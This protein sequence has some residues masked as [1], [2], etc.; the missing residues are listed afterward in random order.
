MPYNL[1]GYEG[2]TR[3]GILFRMLNLPWDELWAS[4]VP[5]YTCIGDFRYTLTNITVHVKPAEDLGPD[6]IFCP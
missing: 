3:G 6:D 5:P 2:P 1:T 4:Y